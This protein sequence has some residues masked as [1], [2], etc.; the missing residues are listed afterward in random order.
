MLTGPA[1]SADDV[2]RATGAQPVGDLPAGMCAGVSTDTRSIHRGQL[3]FALRG[4]RFDAHRFLDQATQAWGAV[5][6]RGVDRPDVDLPVF[7]V[8]DTTRALG[9]L[10]SFHRERLSPLPIVAITGSNGKTTTKELTAVALSATSAPGLKTDGNFNNLVGVPLTL[11]RLLGHE[12]WAVVEMGMNAPGEIARLSEIAR[13]QVG[14]ITNVA[15]VHLEGLGSIDRVAQAKGEL[16]RGLR[17]DATAVVN[18]DDPLLPGVADETGAGGRL[19]MITFG[20]HEEADFRLGDVVVQG[21]QGTRFDVSV[22]ERFGGGVLPVTLQLLGRHNAMNACAALAATAAL[23]FELPAA[24]K[25]LAAAT[26]TGRRLRPRYAPSGALVVDDSYNANLLSMRAAL[27]TTG[28]L[29]TARGGRLFVACGDMLELGESEASMHRDL[30]RL[31]A[32]GAA[33]R[34][35]AFGPRS[36]SAAE[37]ALSERAGDWVLHTESPEEAAAFLTDTLTEKDVVLVKGSRAM[38][39]ERIV[40]RIVTEERQ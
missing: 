39:M 23:G 14:V 1:F 31:V 8:F 38:K 6:E 22:S 12:R 28:E 11:F 37:T 40:D 9:D 30:G 33:V 16:W 29:A 27:E 17:D 4:E 35:V 19:R 26:S 13:P 20:R 34:F 36:E 2:L 18:I 10:A 21:E 24:A 15:P 3:F 32:S 7:E 5:V 25:G